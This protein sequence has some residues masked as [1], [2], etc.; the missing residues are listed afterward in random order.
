L[1]NRS[2]G[3]QNVLGYSGK[4]YQKL[5]AES[6][7]VMNKDQA[8][9]P[10]V[11]SRAGG[12]SE[13]RRNSSSNRFE[14]EEVSDLI[15]RL[16][17][18]V[19]SGDVDTA[20]RSLAELEQGAT[21]GVVDRRSPVSNV[22]SRQQESAVDASSP[23]APFITNTTIL[24]VLAALLFGFADTFTSMLIFTRGG[25]ESNPVLAN[26]IVWLGGSIWAF[27]FVKMI[28]LLVLVIGFYNVKH[29]WKWI[30]PLI[31]SVVGAVLVINNL[32]S[33]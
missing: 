20:Q 17:R 21:S 4:M 18:V 26:I 30:I 10:S 27:V 28:A 6:R 3:E 32:Q 19:A 33:L 1:Q 11:S 8:V 14:P 9:Q 12:F 13:A 23:A 7:F 24:W 2:L 31:V 5:V 29:R 22:N 15:D 16:K 25:Y